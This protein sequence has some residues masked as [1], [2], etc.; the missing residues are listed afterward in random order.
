[1]P[2][3]RCQCS[4]ANT[5]SRGR[6]ISPW[7]T[8]VGAVTL[9]FFAATLAQA[10]VTNP[11]I[12]VIGQ[13]SISL[14]AGSG[15]PGRNRPRLDAGETEMVIDSYLNPYARGTFVFTYAE[16][17]AGVEEACFHLLRGLPGG[18]ALKGGRYRVGFGRLNLAHPHTYPFAERFHLLA[19]YLPGEEA[20]NE[21]GLSLSGRIP[22][23]GDFSLVATADWLQGDTFRSADEETEEAGGWH[24]ALCGRLT[25]F[26]LLG[27]QSGLELGISGTRGIHDPAADRQTTILGADF[28]AKVWRSPRSYLVLQGEIMHLSRQSAESIGSFGGYL[29]ADYSLST[30]SNLGASFER[31]QQPTPDRNWESAVGLF[32]GFA[33][34]EETTAFRLSWERHQLP[35]PGAAEDGLVAGGPEAVH[36]FI[37]RV[38]YSLGPHK[39]HQF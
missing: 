14:T 13:P 4:S 1:M 24:P 11:D 36:T 8:A 30:R 25:G 6:A 23:G 5:C 35:E 18:F 33:L 15:T 7:T 38:L 22:V 19:A 31:F 12:S 32:A 17:E 28:K 2:T 27:E 37:L 3:M 10:G 26:A 9:W 21:T 34:M 20:F 29:Y 16:G 39:A